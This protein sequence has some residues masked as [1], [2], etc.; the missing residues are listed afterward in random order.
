MRSLEKEVMCP[1]PSAFRIVGQK[2]KVLSLG[3]GPPAA[4]RPDPRDNCLAG[5]PYIIC[6]AG[7]DRCTLGLE[8]SDRQPTSPYK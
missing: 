1:S 7:L 5:S 2:V 3:Q 4:I 8:C 6:G